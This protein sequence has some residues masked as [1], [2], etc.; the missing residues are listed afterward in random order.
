[1]A[2]GHRNLIL[3]ITDTLR[4]DYLG[5]YGNEWIKTPHIDAFARRAVRFHQC[6]GEGLPTIQARRVFM[7]GRELLPFGDDRQLKGNDPRLPG[8][9]PLREDDVTL[10]ERLRE[11]G[12]WNGLVTDLW[13]LFKPT[14]NFHR[15][16][17]T[18]EFIRGQEADPWRHGPKGRFNVRDHLPERMIDE[19]SERRTLQY[20]Y[21]T[22]G[23][24]G[25]EDTFAA[26]TM[27]AAAQWLEDCRDRAP[28]FL[29]VDCF[30]PHEYFDPPR[31]YA[32]LYHDHYA[33]ERPLYGYR[34]DGAGVLDEDVPWIR[35][36]Y[37]G[38]VS[39]VDTWVGALLDRV[40]SL[41]LFEDTVV[42][43]VS[44]H[45]IEFSEH[46][47]MGKGPKQL[48]STVTRLPL[49]IH[50]PGHESLAGRSVEGLVSAVDLAPT[51]LRLIGQAPPER[52]T[53]LDAWA[54]ATGE[55]ERIRGHLLSGYGR[56]GA[57][58]DE[59]HLLHVTAH[60]NAVHMTGGDGPAPAL[61]DL[62]SDPGET[63]NVI[64]R[65]PDEARRLLA[66]AQAVW[67]DARI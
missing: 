52:M 9:R 54:L 61:Y 30:S 25:E 24:R 26:R 15:G 3:I 65:R 13:H 33:F 14:M 23:V 39:L 35:G 21:N 10:A 11:R 44:D 66:R 47:L 42:A 2:S 27:R 5:C 1:M 31:A 48:F 20:L 6:H 36:L 16:F 4:A 22:D 57:A 56:G 8:W 59:R 58:R 40:E 12:Y 62:S 19:E 28:F 7:T 55:R 45:G 32:D 60:P 50:A 29:C 64:D 46:G 49:L 51:L 17:D 63:V 67:P 34:V 37:A 43:F 53:G 18:W 38:M 41:G